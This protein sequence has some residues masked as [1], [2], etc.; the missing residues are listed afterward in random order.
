MEMGLHHSCSGPALS[1]TTHST[2]QRCL[3]VTPLD[4]STPAFC[5]ENLPH[6]TTCCSSAA[7]EA[8]D[9]A[10]YPFDPTTFIQPRAIASPPD[11]RD[12]A[13]Q[14]GRSS[15]QGL[16]QDPARGTGTWEQWDGGKGGVHSNQTPPRRQMNGWMR[17]SGAN[18][19]ALLLGRQGRHPP[20]DQRPLHSSA[21]PTAVLEH[22]LP[23]APSNGLTSASHCCCVPRHGDTANNTGFQPT[24]NNGS[25]IPSIA[26]CQHAVLIVL[27]LD[28]A[29]RQRVPAHEPMIHPLGLP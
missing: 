11:I 17:S 8:G 26:G 10:C 4:D 29:G 13:A 9:G 28:A 15:A 16:R 5:N 21:L 14:P 3:D 2:L 23:L 6:S 24:L 25:V 1:R 20:H 12:K 19:C 18:A 7:K 27:F 22:T